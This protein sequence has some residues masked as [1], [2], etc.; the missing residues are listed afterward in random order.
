MKFSFIA[1]MTGAVL[2]AA[3]AMAHVTLEKAE[4]PAGSTYK[5]VL[6]VGHGCDGHATNTLRVKIP[7]GFYNA[8]PM[9][10]PGWQLKTVTGEYARPFDDH[11][12]KMT[13]GVREIIWSGGALEDGW[14]DEFVLRGSVGPDA[15]PGS[16][17]YFPVVQECGKARAQWINV[18]GAEDVPDPAPALTVT[19]ADAGHA[20]HG[21]AAGHGDH[22]GHGSASDGDHA[23]AEPVTAGDL[24]LTGGF[25]RAT[26]PNAEVAGGF[27]TV[28]NT[29]A[30]D[31]RLV[32]ATSP[33]AERVEIH[34]MSM[35][36]DVMRMRPLP[37]GVPLPAGQTVELKPGG[38][39]LM[40]MDLK[41][42]L[43]QG[44]TVP[45]TLTFEK[46]GQVELPLTVGAINAKGGEHAG[47]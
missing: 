38:I 44:Q 45:V 25:T 40:M 20:G 5:A 12:T 41:Q 26:L 43:A 23:E 47:H 10:K 11:G 14:F 35:Q 29:G 16:V 22:A 31:D 18:T 1:A 30:Q 37:E 2:L 3:P 46:A 33:V 15:V 24:Q 8:K 32:S 9:P 42:P 39:H 34:Q 36:G 17:L 13:Q 7:D 21:A 6:R 27:L 4:A 28:T 19:K